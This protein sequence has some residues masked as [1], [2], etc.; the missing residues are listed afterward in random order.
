MSS[1]KVKGIK[2]SVEVWITQNGICCCKLLF[3]WIQYF[4]DVELKASQTHNA[5]CVG[6]FDGCVCHQLIRREYISHKML[7]LVVS[8]HYLWSGM[9]TEI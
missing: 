1:F 4:N 8:Y 3:H 5:V 9:S 2:A 7:E 6:F